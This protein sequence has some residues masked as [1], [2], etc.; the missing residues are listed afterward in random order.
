MLK[1]TNFV[2]WNNFS[3]FHYAGTKNE[4]IWDQDT[5]FKLGAITYNAV[6]F[7][8]FLTGVVLNTLFSASGYRIAIKICKDCVLETNE[9]VENLKSLI[10]MQKLAE[11]LWN[12]EMGPSDDFV[13]QYI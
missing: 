3:S 5:N 1:L 12:F 4:L 8:S 9:T 7:A 6:I 2:L 11:Q 13:C 10:T